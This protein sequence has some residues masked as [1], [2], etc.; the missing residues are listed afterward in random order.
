ML[1]IRTI[2]F[3]RYSEEEISLTTRTTQTA[4]TPECDCLTRQAKRTLHEQT[5]AVVSPRLR[6]VEV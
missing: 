2:P 5:R 3:V 4:A 6:N 1:R